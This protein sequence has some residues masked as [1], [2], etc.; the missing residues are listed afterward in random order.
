MS[1]LSRST[2]R[3]RLP[4]LLGTAQIG[5]IGPTLASALRAATALTERLN[6]LDGGGFALVGDPTHALAQIADWMRSHGH[7]GAWRNEQLAV[8]NTQGEQLATVERGATR[9]LGITTQSVHMVGTTLAGKAWVQQRSAS[10]ADDPGL[11]DT[12]VGGMIGARET[13]QSALSREA[14]EEAGLDCT[15]LTQRGNAVSD[16]GVVTFCCEVPSGTEGLM[17][18]EVRAVRCLIPDDVVPKNQ[19]GEVTAF[20][21]LTLDALADQIDAG[22]FTV[23]A[24]LVI[25]R[26]LGWER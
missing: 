16:C 7:T 2:P 9:P 24:S 12:L 17:V 6:P 3:D 8:R 11:W 10:K 4:L 1:R 5:S 18:E 25:A 26:C 15:E 20:A 19:D 23:V 21:C 13:W 14:W 22:Q